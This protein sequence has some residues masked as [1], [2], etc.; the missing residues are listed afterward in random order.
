M[1]STCMA[2][3]PSATSHQ[4]VGWGREGAAGHM[5]VKAPVKWE[6]KREMEGGMERGEIKR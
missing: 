5:R 3:T 4:H 1:L 2:N 6:S